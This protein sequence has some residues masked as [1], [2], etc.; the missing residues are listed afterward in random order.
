[1]GPGLPTRPPFKFRLADRGAGRVCGFVDPGRGAVDRLWTGTER[2]LRT[3][4]PWTSPQ[5][6]H[7]PAGLARL[8]KLHSLYYY[9]F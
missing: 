2:L 5:P 8:H 3:V 1:M 4:L 7:S 6:D 9:L